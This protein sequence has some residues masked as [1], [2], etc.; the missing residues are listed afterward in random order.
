MTDLTLPILDLSRLD[1][2]AEAAARFR[3]DLRAATHDVGFFY[4][5][6]TG[7]TPELES[8]L[9]RAARD[10][11]A[12]PEA[13]K[14]AIENVKSPHFRGYTRIGGERTQGKVDWREQI[15]IGPER[16]AVTDP[17][18]PDF[19]RLIGP[20]LWPEAQPELREVVS[21]WHDHLSGVARKLLRA[22]ALSLGAPESY[23]DEHFGEP[24]T[25][26]KIVRYPGK[27][28]PAPPSPGPLHGSPARSA[29]PPVAWVQGV[30]AHK[31]SGVLTLLWVEPGKGGLQVERDR[32]WVDAPPVPGAFVVNIGEL[33]EYA[34]QGYLI[35]TNHRVISPRHP[36]DR[37]S[38]PFFFNPALD[39]RLPLIDLP[40]E[41]AE[42]A[43]GLT[44]DP[45]N[46]IHALYGENAL[47]SRL[48]A[49]PD[50][51]GIHHAD[52]V[53]AREAA[54]A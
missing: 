36:D 17:A 44:Q 40:P 35:A 8:R 16:E 7:V 38:V 26:I 33:L 5:T 23:F 31:D 18:A 52:L 30:G 46:P 45:A 32:E 47:K 51:A 6:G 20:N 12:L 53:A 21:E 19:A 37:I 39:K 50:V 29:E 10:F 25:L 14:L 54:S 27:A 48:R 11:F 41:F 15:D 13:D 43:K 2:G 24:S 9:H 49:H 4:L 34:T 22:W 3:D 28:D 1:A 42:Q